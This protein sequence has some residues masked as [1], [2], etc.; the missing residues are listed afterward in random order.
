VRI[1]T[2]VYGIVAGLCIVVGSCATARPVRMSSPD[3][4]EYISIS[5]VI[6]REQSGQ[7]QEGVRVRIFTDP[8]RVTVTDYK[9]R[10]QFDSLPWGPY[11]VVAD[12]FGWIRETRRVEPSCSVAVLDSTG[13]ILT[14]ARCTDPAEQLN[15]SMRPQRRHGG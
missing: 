5:G 12:G 8:V 1:S 14:R 2:R 13:A 6:V 9:G 10:Y 15:F 4:P 7:P 3:W 11:E